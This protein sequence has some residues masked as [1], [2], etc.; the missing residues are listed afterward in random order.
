MLYGLPC[1][2]LSIFFHFF[3]PLSLKYILCICAVAFTHQREVLLSIGHIR[4]HQHNIHFFPA[5]RQLDVQ[6]G[7]GKVVDVSVGHFWTKAN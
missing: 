7:G 5:Y 6:A 3:F 4:G 1:Q 2:S